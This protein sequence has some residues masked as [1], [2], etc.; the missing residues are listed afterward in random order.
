MTMY[1]GVDLG[2]SS[3]K[4][5]LADDNGRIADS[6]S[7]KYPLSLPADGWSE[8]DPAD[9]YRGVVSCIRELGSRHSLDEVRGVSF[10]G[11]MHGLVVLDRDDNVI[12]PAILWNDNRTVE[13]CAYLNDVVGKDK[14]LEWTGNVAFT[15]FTAPKLMWLK[16]HEPDNF[17]RIA[18]IM[19]PK[20]FIAYKMSGVFGSDVSDD[21]GTLYFDVKNRRWST[22]MLDLIGISEDQLPAVFDSTDVIGHVSG[23]FAA[24]SGLP[25][26]AKVVMGGGD[27]AVGAVGTGTVKEGSMFF[28]LGTSGVVFA[29][30][31]EFAASTNGGMHVFRHANGRFHFMGCMLSAAGSMQWWSEAVTGMSVGDLLDE[32]P[33]ECTDAPV[34]LPY[35]TGERSPINDPNAK[36][37]FYGIEL[38]HK[39][40]DMTKAVVDG[41]CFGLKDCYDNILGMGAKT[42][43]AR[44]IGGGSRSDKWVQI[45]ADITG[46]ELRRINTS[47]GAGLGAVILAMVGCGEFGSLDEA[48][49]ALIADTDVFLP[50][51][52]QH[53]AYAERFAAFKDLYA[54]LK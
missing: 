32:M 7:A 42:D 20:D 6:A 11:Q 39:R 18:K 49:G 3:V 37:A 9:W 44:V 14:L 19:L 21:S 46:L 36:G 27:Q 17:A 51:E 26:S 52:R 31:A 34:F 40:A 24:A 43:F 10:S 2:T 33:G 45:L 15:G 16:R 48:C 30:C 4:L 50:D 35:L 5:V 41:I 23:E 47:D 38:S 12:R 8:Q 25:V 1:L 53:M 28:S 22:P 13:E 54:R 29:P